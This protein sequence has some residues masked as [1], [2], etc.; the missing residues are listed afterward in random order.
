MARR[1]I[2][3][4]ASLRS[5]S[6]LAATSELRMLLPV[7]FPPGWARLATKAGPDE[8]AD[9]DHD[10]GNCR[11]CLLGRLRPRRADGHDDVYGQLGHAAATSRSGRASADRYSM[12]MFRPSM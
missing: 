8:I 10:D 9:P 3:G 6:R 12:A 1:D 11:R 4:T 2:V 5:C 7:I